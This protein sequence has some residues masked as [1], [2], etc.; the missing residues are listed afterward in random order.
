MHEENPSE[1]QAQIQ[2]RLQEMKLKKELSSYFENH[3]ITSDVYLT[4]RN[5]L[6]IFE[7]RITVKMLKAIEEKQYEKARAYEDCLE[8]IRENDTGI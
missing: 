5:K 8:I 1:L 6:E 7:H 3:K 4:L 2:E